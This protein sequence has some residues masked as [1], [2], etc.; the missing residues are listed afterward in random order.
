[1]SRARLNSLPFYLAI[2]PQR[3]GTS[4]LD[5]YLRY[6]RDICLPD[7]VKEIFFFDR[8]FHK[9]LK[10]Y[11]D[12]FKVE[13]EHKLAMEF[14]TTSF[15]CPEAPGRVLKLF[16][17]HIRLLCPLRD[18]ITRSYSLFRHYQRYGMVSGDLR[19]ACED[20]PQI[21]TSSHY[22]E[23][24]ER[25]FD[26]FPPENIQ[27]IYQETLDANQSSYVRQ[28]CDFLQIPFIDIPDDLS[29]KYNSTTKPPSSHLARWA[30]SSAEYLR[31]RGVY[32]PINF[33]KRLGVKKLIFGTE[34]RKADEATMTSEEQAFLWEKLG[35]EQ[36]KLDHFLARHKE[37]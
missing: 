5:R 2:G 9:G 14:T 23:H 21:L 15:D 18:P 35:K 13:P 25:W 26:L 12:H 28:V 34:G 1:M 6:R 36:E 10:F 8:H 3:A 31:N 33:A 24:L 29:A 16:G 30:Q 19:Q 22:T 4:W 27:I 37:N 20:L 17:S 7:K 32:G 11:E